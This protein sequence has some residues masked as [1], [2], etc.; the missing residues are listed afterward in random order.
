MVYWLVWN[1]IWTHFLLD[2][3][4]G[5]SY[6]RASLGGFKQHFLL[7][8][9]LVSGPP[10]NFKTLMYF[11]VAVGS[12]E[13]P[14]NVDDLMNEYRRTIRFI[15][16]DNS[17]KKMA[18]CNMIQYHQKPMYLMIPPLWQVVFLA[19]CNHSKWMFSPLRVTVISH[20][21]NLINGM[22]K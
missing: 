21:D 18:E 10:C 6:W 20:L 8:C 22:H 3:Q 11:V 5:P 17:I 12:E 14:C 19:S 16:F 4:E 15:S 2:F 13:T 9:H 1:W 7:R